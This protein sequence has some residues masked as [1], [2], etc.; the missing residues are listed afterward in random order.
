MGVGV[1]IK[2]KIW[3]VGVK[4]NKKDGGY[5]FFWNIPY[6]ECLT[7]SPIYGN[8]SL[9]EDDT[10]MTCFHNFDFTLAL[11]TLILV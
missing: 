9:H 11:L 5:G 7:C 4:I 3:G 6:L 10:G 2:K 8:Q 1:K